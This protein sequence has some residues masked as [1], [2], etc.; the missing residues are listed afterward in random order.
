[1]PST[2]RVIVFHGALLSMV[3]CF[4]GAVLSMVLC[5]HGAVL[6]M[7]LC[8]HSAVLSTVPFSRIPCLLPWLR[9][10]T[11]FSL[12]FFPITDWSPGETPIVQSY[13]KIHS[14]WSKSQPSPI[15]FGSILR[16]PTVRHLQLHSLYG[17][18][19]CFSTYFQSPNFA[20]T[21]LG[22]FHLSYSITH[23]FS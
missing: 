21:K 8:F 6:S 4:H 19:P 3:L 5:F 14:K 12:P 9:W 18:L 13:W 15:I 11:F 17:I 2:Q 1:M 20:V 23:L 7:V 22:S 16:D 10:R